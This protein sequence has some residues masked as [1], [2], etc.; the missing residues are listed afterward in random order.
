MEKHAEYCLV[1]EG[2]YFDENEAEHALRDPFIEEWVEQTGKFK[3]HNF[4]DIDVAGGISLG[5]LS[6]ATIDEEMFRIFC[7]NRA[8]FMNLSKANQLAEAI[9]RQGMFDEVSVQPLEQNS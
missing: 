3:I 7:H 6:V 5:D 8:R 9:R 1:V 4:D 2:N